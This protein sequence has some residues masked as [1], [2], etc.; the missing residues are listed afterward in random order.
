M[1]VAIN[2]IKV[3]KVLS[4]SEIFVMTRGGNKFL[5]TD[6]EGFGVLSSKRESHT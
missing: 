2:N 1:G 3:M 6:K 4:R 5:N